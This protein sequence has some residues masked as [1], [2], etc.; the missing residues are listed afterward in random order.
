[1]PNVYEIIT[2]RIIEQL[3]KNVVPWRKPWKS[4]PPLNLVSKKEY[5]GINSILLNSL[6][7]ENP[8]FLSFKQARELG[9]FVRRGERGFP[10]VF[11]QMIEKGEGNDKETFPLLRYYTVFNVAQTEGVEIPKAGVRESNSIDECER[12]V[13]GMPNP[14]KIAFGGNQA[15]YVPSRDLITLPVRKRFDSAEEFYS[16]LLHEMVH[17]TGHASRLNRKGINESGVGFGSETYSQ[18]ELVAEI[19]SSFLNA[20]AGIIGRTIENS[21]SY[22]ANW[23]SVLRSDKRMITLAAGAAQK[24]SDYILGAH[25]SE[26]SNE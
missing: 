21:A 23:L 3:E 24:A 2:E 13:S 16:T 20:K 6:L 18:E 14:P 7:F 22:I 12:I 26:A 1:M 8:Y 19:G 17:S 25:V 10:V 5:R 4:I 9:G 11:W 15:F